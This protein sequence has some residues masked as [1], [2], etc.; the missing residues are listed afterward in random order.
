MDLRGV[1]V[2]YEEEV[3]LFSGDSDTDTLR[4]D[5]KNISNIISSIILFIFF[6]QK[7]RS[8]ED[9]WL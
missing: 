6:S 7:K 9:I 4:S 3:C 2:K 8:D 1:K 5:E